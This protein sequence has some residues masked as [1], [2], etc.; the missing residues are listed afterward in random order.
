MCEHACC[1]PTCTLHHHFC[2]GFWVS[3]HMEVRMKSIK[4]CPGRLMTCSRRANT[5]ITL[6]T[7]TLVWMRDLWALPSRGWFYFPRFNRPSV[8]I[9]APLR[10]R[11]R[12]SWFFWPLNTSNRPGSPALLLWDGVGME[13]AS[14]MPVN[15]HTGCCCCKVTM[16]VLMM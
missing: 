6:S 4:R 10:W 3:L 16:M 1:L 11:Q 12:E 15:Q 5:P 9:W 14:L 8:E 2:V 13:S 7:Y